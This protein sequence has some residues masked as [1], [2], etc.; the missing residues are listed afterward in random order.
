[1]AQV[2]GES[3]LGCMGHALQG[4]YPVLGQVLGA[5]QPLT[6]TGINIHNSV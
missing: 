2:A 5:W 3:L 1:M 6:K 4:Q